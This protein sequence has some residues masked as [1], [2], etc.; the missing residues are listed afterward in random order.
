MR[1]NFLEALNDNIKIDVDKCVYCGLCVETCILD[2]LRMKL[3]PCRQACP[4]EVNCHGY[5]RCIARGED[6]KAMVQ[7]EKTLPF[8]GVLGRICSQPCEENCHRR[9]VEGKAVAIRA[10]KRY[11]SDNDPRPELPVPDMAPDSGHRA[12]VVG[13]GPA[14]LMAAYELRLRGHAVE[15]YDAESE[16]GGM[17]RWAIPSFRLPR[18]VLEREVD[19]L[20]RMGVVFRMGV[21]LA[22]DFT[23][24]DIKQEHEAVVAALG[25]PRPRM[26]G[27][28]GEN[29]EGVYHAL[30]FLRSVRAGEEPQLGSRVVVVGGGDVALD[31]AQT[32]LRLGAKEVVSVCLESEKEVPAHD[33]I[34]AGALEEGVRLKCSWGPVR[35]IV[36]SGSVKSVEF[37]RCTSVFNETG[38]FQPCFLESETCLEDADSVI[39][40]IG[41]QAELTAL[42][43]IGAEGGLKYDPLTKQSGSDP[44]V[45]VAGD[46]LTGPSSAVWAMASGREAAISAD[47]FMRGEHLKY[48]RSYP[49][50][51]VTEYDIDTSLGS[52]ADR[53]ALPA[54]P[55]SGKGDFSELELAYDEEEARREAGRCYSCGTP[56]GCYRTCWFC[57]PCEVECPHDA[58][59]VEVPYLLR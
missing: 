18:E 13:S 14:G 22:K 28:E 40:S 20:R 56:F 39:V 53:T 38:G 12:A 51:V 9:K 16:P 35:I 26:L 24:D 44:A 6:D 48:G 47:R 31:A 45:F 21:R 46:M 52:D 42:S 30:P 43:A 49:G 32:A 8:H 36:Q 17:L 41:Q 50:P 11:L 3:A 15:I 59:W 29:A 57:L 55:Y 1:I 33:Y 34:L 10:L 27:I 5:V 54:K 4:L 58:L 2:N 19:R 23:L 25:C 37:K 7:L